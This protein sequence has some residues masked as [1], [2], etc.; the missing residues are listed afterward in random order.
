MLYWFASFKVSSSEYAIMMGED[1][2]RPRSILVPRC[3]PSR[4]Q[5]RVGVVRWSVR[6]STDANQCVRAVTLHTG[7]VVITM[8]N[9]TS[10]LKA[11]S[12]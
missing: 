8:L 7:G 4:P 6:Q 5:R 9:P 1:G 11:E 10:T 12:Q 3:E 2:D